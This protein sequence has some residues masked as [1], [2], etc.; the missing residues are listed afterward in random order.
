MVKPIIAPSILASDFANLGC[1]CHRIINAGADWL[2]IDVMDGHFVPNI[3][4]GQPIVTSLRRSVPRP[5]DTTSDKP[6][7]FFDCHMMVENPETWVDDFVKCGAD[8]FTF[9]YEATKDPLNLVKLIKSKGIKAACAIKPT[10]PVDVLYE[11]GAHLDMALVMTVEPGF[12]GQKFMADMMPKVEA[13]RLKFPNL[14]IQVDGG[15]SKDTIPYAAKA[16]ANVI[17]AGTSVFTASDPQDV[18]SFM[19]KEVS[20][21]MAT[22]NLLD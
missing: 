9:H 10:T 12:G 21:E 8:Q 13:L 11:L 14:N 4:L 20:N 18:I 19:K 7:A 17:V 15:L 16:G 5:N 3:T 22:R 6:K 1:D 2:H